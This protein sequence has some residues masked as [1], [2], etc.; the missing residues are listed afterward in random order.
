MIPREVQKQSV[1]QSAHVRFYYGSFEFNSKFLKVESVI[2]FKAV[3][4]HIKSAAV[5]RLFMFLKPNENED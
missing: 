3:H 4:A 5:V 1:A 2:N